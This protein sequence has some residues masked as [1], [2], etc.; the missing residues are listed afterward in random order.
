[1]ISNV[2]VARLLE[3][4]NFGIYALVLT[5]ISVFYA[6]SS[7]GLN[8]LTIR[9]V[10]RDQSNSIHYLKLSMSLRIIG[11]VIA[12]ILFSVY[13]YVFVLNYPTLIILLILAGIFLENVWNGLQNIAFGMQHMEWNSIVNVSSSLLLL[14]IYLILP[15]SLFIVSF[16]FFLHI[17]IL[18]LKDV[19]Y[20][21]SL[22]KSFLLRE[23]TKNQCLTTKEMK[24]FLKESFPFYVLTLLGLF[25]NQFPT[26]FLEHNSGVESVAYFSTANKLLLPLTIFLNTAISA[27]FP[28]QS[29]LYNSDRCRFGKQTVRVI[30]IVTIIGILI[31]FVISAFRQEF[32]F[33]LYGDSYQSTADVM[34][35]QCWYLVMYAIFCFNGSTLGAADAQRKLS[36]CSIVYAIVSTPI[37]Y[38]SS[39][40]G[41]NGLSIGYVVASIIN[42][43]YIFPVLKKVL[44][45]ALTWRFYFTY[46]VIFILSLGVSMSISQ[47]L[48]I[49]MRI[50]IVIVVL[51]I[52]YLSRNKLST[53]IEKA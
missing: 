51:S 15:K 47:S 26:L 40:Y 19:G 43:M 50:I 29:Q 44:N 8:Q 17:V 4:E 32:V 31:S 24:S 3:P 41:A 5:Y 42:I 33:L 22:K 49:W 11:F 23:T 28:N 7:L 1:M 39:R 14:I 36:M 34:A 25:T 30:W 6:I 38:F 2:L 52:I 37:L 46:M 20:Y 16:I 45:N 18:C 9:S 12:A 21:I 13:C 10:A 35:W 27:F 53:L 48:S